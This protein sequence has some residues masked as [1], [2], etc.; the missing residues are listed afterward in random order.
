MKN[1]DFTDNSLNEMLGKSTSKETFKVPEGYFEELSGNIMNSI[2]SLPDFEKQTS[3]QP[4]SVP[5][6]YFEQLP[7]HINERIL[8]TTHSRSSFLNW[9]FRPA[10]LIPAAFSLALLIGGYFYFTRTQKIEIDSNNTCS[11]E[12]ISESTYL[13]S[14]SDDDIIDFIAA[15]QD[16]KTIDEYDQYL[17]DNDVDIS[18]LEKNL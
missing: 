7:S 17:L 13:Q 10:R 4:F 6:N 12:D 16:D 1:T 3:T 14:M 2:Q 11:V 8:L 9:L 5:E 18:Q 15:Q